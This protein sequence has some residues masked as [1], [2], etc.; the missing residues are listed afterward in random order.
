MRL[1]G[2]QE[3]AGR[4]VFDRLRL[5]TVSTQA[6]YDAFFAAISAPEAREPREMFPPGFIVTALETD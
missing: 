5:G 3:L 2:G 6:G 4:M 1:Y